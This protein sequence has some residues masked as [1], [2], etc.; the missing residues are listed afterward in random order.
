MSWDSGSFKVI[1]FS[2]GFEEIQS[3]SLDEQGLEKA[4]RVGEFKALQEGG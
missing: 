3:G 2:E 1:I 4:I